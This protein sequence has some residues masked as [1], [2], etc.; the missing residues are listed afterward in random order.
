MEGIVIVVAIPLIAAFMLIMESSRVN[1]E[2]KA[3][4]K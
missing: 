4:Q 2:R 1:S 3:G